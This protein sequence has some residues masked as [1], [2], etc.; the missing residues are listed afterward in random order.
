MSANEGSYNS[1]NSE[2]GAAR[3]ALTV[4]FTRFGARRFPLSGRDALAD[5]VLQQRPC[6]ETMHDQSSK[7]RSIEFISGCKRI[8]VVSGVCVDA[9]RKRHEL[10]V[11]FDR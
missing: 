9:F 4:L 1:N 6:S 11:V 5:F 7:A 10:E 3:N 2:N 8:G